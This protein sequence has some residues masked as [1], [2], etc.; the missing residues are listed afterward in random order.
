[1]RITFEQIDG[2]LSLFRGHWQLTPLEDGQ[3][4]ACL[5]MEFEI[6]IPLLAAMLDPLAVDALTTNTTAMFGA[7]EQRAVD[8]FAAR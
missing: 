7:L 5:R 8:P 1:M 4:R 3:T 6:G 2:D